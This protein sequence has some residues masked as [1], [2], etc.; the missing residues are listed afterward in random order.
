MK[1]LV[2]A[3]LCSYG[4]LIIGIGIRAVVILRTARTHL[5]NGRQVRFRE[6]NVLTELVEWNGIF[7]GALIKPVR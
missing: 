5:Q 6:P 3:S 2:P 1:S 4:L 7:P